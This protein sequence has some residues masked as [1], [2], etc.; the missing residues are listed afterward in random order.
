MT[1]LVNKDTK[2]VVQGATGREGSTHTLSMLKYGTNI[3][4]GVTP[5]KGG[6]KVD[7]VTIYETVKQ[8]K[9]AYPEINASIIFVPAQFAAD[10]VYEA[11]DSEIKLIVT[12]TEKV[13]VH[14]S[15]EF[16]NYAREKGVTIIGPNCPGVISPD[17]S[18]VGIMPGHIFSRGNVGM[19]S[20]SGTLT[21]E[22]AWVLT[23]AG[24]GQSTAVGIG[25]DPVTGRDILE[26]V[27]MFEKD[28][29]TKAIVAIGEIGG[30]A[31]ERLAHRIK[32]RGMKKPIV[33]F[34]AGRQAP[35]GKRMGHAGAIISMGS[36]T[37]AS[38]IEALESAG[39]R[40]AELPSQIPELVREALNRSPSD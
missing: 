6:E 2:V 17:A 8:A 33:S 30:D 19:V 37:A 31:E 1:I 29:D 36:G 24:F 12:I 22:I 7:S 20:R 28:P 5:G 32:E 40:V 10:A 14:D 15:L 3:M 35:P 39:I 11:L 38:K 21:Y 16:V 23:K 13:P 26:I 9:Q 25:G 34:I 4:A 27:D 18:K